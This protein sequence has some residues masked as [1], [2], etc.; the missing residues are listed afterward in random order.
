MRGWLREVYYLCF[1]AVLLIRCRYADV[2]NVRLAQ[3]PDRIPMPPALLRYRVSEDVDADLFMAIGERTTQNIEEVLMQANRP[4]GDF[5]F[6]LDFGCGCGR[7]LTWLARQFPDA[8]FHGT[9][10][11]KEAIGWCRAHLPIVDW[12]VNTAQP[13]LGYRSNAFDLIYAIS[14][15]THLDARH[16]ERWLAEFARILQPG[17]ILLLS[18][19][20]DGARREWDKDRQQRLEREGF[21]FET[22]TKLRGIV[23][24]WYHTAHHTREYAVSQVAAHLR[25]L[26]YIPGGMGHQDALIARRYSASGS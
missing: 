18:V 12:Q 19:H 4:L 23:P 20:G 22:S 10:V 21:L 25:V 9:D 3:A 26:A 1:R 14:V 16:Q 11:D 15:F 2:F 7:T 17:G 6:I 24:E 13:P 8:K 5:R